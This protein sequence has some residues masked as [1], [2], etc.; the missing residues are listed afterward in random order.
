VNAV[1][2]DAVRGFHAGFYGASNAE[3]SAVGDI[4]APEVRRALQAAFGDWVSPAPYARVPRPLV[5]IKPERVLLNTPDKQNA[6]LLVHQS[7]PL[8]E[9]DPDYP[10]LVM[11]N[12]LLG[13][14]GSSRL[15]TRIREA[16]GLSYDVHSSI[17]WNPHEA[18]SDWQASAIFA[19]QNRARV[20]AAFQEELAR[21]L[22]DGFSERELA[23]GKLGLLNFRR[24]SRAQDAS[25][26]HALANNLYLGRT[27][28]VS[29]QV[30]AALTKL[31]LAQVNAA[32]RTYIKPEAFVLAFAGDFK[33]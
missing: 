23:E 8:S 18:N 19:P 10:A 25:V 33:P 2:L 4:D 29:A 31:T 15:W 7:L 24:L 28:A 5:P 22:K 14:G 17:A 30:D 9:R 32:L 12:H 26:A 6:T 1:T 20:E 3:F 16:E 27:F 13:A 11:A 21:A